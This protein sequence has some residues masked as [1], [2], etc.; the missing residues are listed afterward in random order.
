MT[1]NV[2]ALEKISKSR[3]SGVVYLVTKGEPYEGVSTFVRN[4]ELTFEGPFIRSVSE[5]LR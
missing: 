2:K 3:G 4:T 1:E 5:Q